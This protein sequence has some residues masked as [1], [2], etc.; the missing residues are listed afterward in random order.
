MQPATAVAAHDSFSQ[1]SRIA[2]QSVLSVEQIAEE[3]ALACDMAGQDEAADSGWDLQID[4]MG[5][6]IVGVKARDVSLARAGD[7]DGPAGPA[8]LKLEKARIRTG[9]GGALSGG[10]ALRSIAAQGGV[11]PTEFSR[12]LID[13]LGR[14]ELDAKAYGGT[15][16]LANAARCTA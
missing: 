14:R 8:L 16:D 10:L 13:S 2:E 6:A 9:I 12:Q 11:S 1:V 4:S 5:S 7:G 3:S 15:L